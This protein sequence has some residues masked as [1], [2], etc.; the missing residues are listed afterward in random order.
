MFENQ[1]TPL[2]TRSQMKIIDAQIESFIPHPREKVLQVVSD[3]TL[4]M[5]WH[6]WIERVAIYEQKGL[7]YRRLG[8]LGG[9]IELVEKLWSGEDEDTFHTQ[10]VQ[11]LWADYRYRSRIVVSEC[12][13]GCNLRWQGRLLKDKAADEA[14]QM[15]DFF[16]EGLRG[17]RDLLG[18]S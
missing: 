14:A 16:R 12:P 4:I 1:P 9:E 10:S 11:G 6:P 5:S 15:E 8:F 2:V 13:D 3:P 7:V 18:E 17:L